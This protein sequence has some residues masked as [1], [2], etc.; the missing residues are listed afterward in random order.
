[1]SFYIVFAG[2][3]HMH[4]KLLIDGTFHSSAKIRCLDINRRLEARGTGYM[5]ALKPKQYGTFFSERFRSQQLSWSY[6]LDLLLFSTRMIENIAFTMF[7]WLVSP[8][9]R[10]AGHKERGNAFSLVLSHSW[11][12]EALHFERNVKSPWPCYCW[13]ELSFTEFIFRVVC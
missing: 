1:M 4:S 6:L 10:R 7:R 8:E 11:V 9:G 5:S 2:S 3:D 13:K 12:V